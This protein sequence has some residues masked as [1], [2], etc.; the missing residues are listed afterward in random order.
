M[1]D[2]NEK[3]YRC[4]INYAYDEIAILFGNLFDNAIEAAKKS[5][6]K[7]VKLDV[8]IQDVYL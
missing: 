4:S 5:T 1:A 6:E 7:I 3:S 2:G 8:C